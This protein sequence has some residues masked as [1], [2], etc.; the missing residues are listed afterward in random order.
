MALYRVFA[1]MRNAQKRKALV[2]ICAILLPSSAMAQEVQPGH[3]LTIADC[4]PGYVLGV[5]SMAEA[6]PWAEPPTQPTYPPPS[7]DEQN[8]QAAALTSMEAAAPRRFAT[9]CVPKQ[10]QR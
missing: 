6:Q 2:A 7:V 1:T 4:P 3:I 8:R 10:I 9:G 5:Q